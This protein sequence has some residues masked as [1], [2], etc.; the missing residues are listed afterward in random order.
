MLLSSS[1]WVP[2]L[3]GH[4][5]PLPC[6]AFEAVI[7]FTIFYRA[8]AGLGIAIFRLIYINHTDLAGK[9]SPLKYL[10]T[11]G[12]V[13]LALVLTLA[14]ILGCNSLDF[15]NLQILVQRAS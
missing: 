7:D 6:I 11:C 12:G 1:S 5:G 2:S 9:D 8:I 10:F 13:G 4:F 15:G 14:H 3:G